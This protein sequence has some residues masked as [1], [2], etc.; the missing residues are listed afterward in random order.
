MHA[1]VAA[2]TSRPFS[3]AYHFAPDMLHEALRLYRERFVASDE[4]PAPYA[5]LGVNVVCAPTDEQAQ[6]LAGSGQLM[7]ARMQR[8]DL[9]PVPSP[10]TAAA[11]D[12]DDRERAM[13][14][15]RAATAVVG[16]PATVVAGLHAL[17][18][19]TGVQELMLSGVF[20]GAQAQADSLSLVAEAAGLPAR[21]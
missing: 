16:S 6:Y 21:S 4:L 9:Q 18:A 20:H 12:W 13:V 2:L 15:K 17:L 7:F 11:H 10:E 1:Q 3:F 8:G 5:K 14:A 19:D